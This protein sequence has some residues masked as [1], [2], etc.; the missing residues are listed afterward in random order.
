MRL[1]FSAAGPV[2]S[3]FSLPAE[4][5]ERPRR[6]R[7]RPQRTWNGAEGDCAAGTRSCGGRLLAGCRSL[8]QDGAWSRARGPACE[9]R[10]CAAECAG[11]RN[12]SADFGGAMRSADL[13]AA[14][15]SE[16]PWREPPAYAVAFRRRM[17]RNIFG[18]FW[19]GNR[20]DGIA[21]PSR[22]CIC[23]SGGSSVGMSAIGGDS[24]RQALNLSGD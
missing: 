6:E 16:R 21:V 12:K 20:D 7:E 8:E 1:R 9:R 2:F 17:S 4:P 14:R 3:F 11:L 19:C 24:L 10:P 22:A 18:I 15:R 23:K 5:A 13:R